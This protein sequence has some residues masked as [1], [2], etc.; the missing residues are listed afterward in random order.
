MLWRCCRAWCVTVPEQDPHG[1]QGRNCQARVRDTAR[2]CRAQS[3]LDA[4][5]RELV[6]VP[7]SLD[8]D[9][10]ITPGVAFACCCRATRVSHRNGSAGAARRPSPLRSPRQS[11]RRASGG[12]AGAGA[13]GNRRGAPHRK[14]TA[15]SARSRASRKGSN[16][17]GKPPPRGG[18]RSA[19]QSVFDMEQEPEGG[20]YGDDDPMMGGGA[21]GGGAQFVVRDSQDVVPVAAGHYGHGGQA[22]QHG[23]GYSQPH[24]SI[25]SA[26]PQ[27]A[28]YVPHVAIPPQAPARSATTS[29]KMKVRPSRPAGLH[30]TVR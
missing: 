21:M 18:Q 1:R 14:R 22:P 11:P 10:P 13:G 28:S 6:H 9:T 20:M 4:V 17:G 25:Y 24:A 7:L 30:S 2:S 19:P 5:V 26:T 15:G 29:P 16:S 23:G 8:A 27:P 12:G 3:R